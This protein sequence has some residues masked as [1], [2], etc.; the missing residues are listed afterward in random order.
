M[1]CI[2]DRLKGW[3]GNCWWGWEPG[4]VKYRKTTCKGIYESLALLPGL[5]GLNPTSTC[6]SSPAHSQ[7]HP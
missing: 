5:C 7:T 6:S 3:E 1:L 2:S 4:S